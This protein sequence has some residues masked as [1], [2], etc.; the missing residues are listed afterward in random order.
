MYPLPLTGFFGRNN[1]QETKC[2]YGTRP[3][4]IIISTTIRQDIVSVPQFF[5]SDH[6]RRSIQFWHNLLAG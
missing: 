3:R 2:A 4:Q 5:M 6:Q 1:Q